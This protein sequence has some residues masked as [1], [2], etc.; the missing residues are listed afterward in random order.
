MAGVKKPIVTVTP[1]GFLAHVAKRLAPI[2]WRLALAY[3]SFF[4]ILWF[5]NS[6]AP[7]VATFLI[8][9]AA[10]PMPEDPDPYER[11]A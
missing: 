4:A 6:W 10:F 9:A 7:A 5:F 2:L 8:I 11:S 3:G 1:W